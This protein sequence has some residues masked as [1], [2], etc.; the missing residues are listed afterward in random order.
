MLQT[1]AVVRLQTFERQCSRKLDK[2]SLKVVYFFTYKSFTQGTFF[3]ES[4]WLD[5][6]K[7]VRSLEKWQFLGDILVW[8]FLKV[9]V[10]LIHY[11]L[12]F[13]SLFHLFFGQASDSPESWVLKLD[14]LYG[15]C[16]WLDCET[17]S[18]LGL[19]SIQEGRLHWVQILSC[20]LR[21]LG[22]LFDNWFA[23]T[24]D[25]R[26]RSLVWRR[27]FERLRLGSRD[28]LSRTKLCL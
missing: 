18:L 3:M 2:H 25:R 4:N 22:L 6:A 21:L 13:D 24:F 20:V 28:R 15:I 1:F 16:F 11:D 17:S 7:S 23:L 10:L 12:V 14:L 9:P 5:E 27:K 8:F 19:L 26:G